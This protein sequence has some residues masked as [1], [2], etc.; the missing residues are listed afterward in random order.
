[1][2]R[3]TMQIMSATAPPETRVPVPAEPYAVLAVFSYRSIDPSAASV[4]TVLT[5]VSL[6]TQNWYPATGAGI[7]TVQVPVQTKN[8]LGPTRVPLV[9]AVNVTE[10]TAPVL[11]VG[12]VAPVVPVPVAPVAPVLPVG[13]VP[14]VT[15]VLP[16]GPAD[17][18]ALTTQ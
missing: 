13:P 10:P 18:L 16:V 11:P 1:M 17:P 5:F 14:P 9:P 8:A 2:S 12:P 4:M 3:P 15:P 6:Y 7:V